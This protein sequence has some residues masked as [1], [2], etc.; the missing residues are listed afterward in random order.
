MDANKANL[1]HGLTALQS[2]LFNIYNAMVRASP[3]SREGILDF[4]TQVAVLNVRRSGMR[5]NYETVSSD[6]F[7]I[8]IHAVLLKLFEPVMDIQF[9][10]VGHKTDYCFD[11]TLINSD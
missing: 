3:A 5:V 9:S 1:R 11:G 2:S 10:K 7:M 8:N 6:G 4:F